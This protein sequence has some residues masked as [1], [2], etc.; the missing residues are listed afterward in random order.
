MHLFLTVKTLASSLSLPSGGL[1][2]GCLSFIS[3]CCPKVFCRSCDVSEFQYLWKWKL[4]TWKRKKTMRKYYM[5]FL[6]FSKSGSL[7]G[8]IAF[9]FQKQCCILLWGIKDGVEGTMIEFQQH[10]CSNSSVKITW[11]SYLFEYFRHFINVENWICT[12]RYLCHAL[13]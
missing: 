7:Q 13:S 12:Y 6:M 5:V 8:E 1:S 4:M 9:L 11:V 2:L 10:S 3:K